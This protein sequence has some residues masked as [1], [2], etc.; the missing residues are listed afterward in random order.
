MHES[1]EETVTARRPHVVPDVV[2]GLRHWTSLLHI[3]NFPVHERDLEILIDIN[4]FGSQI[5]DFVRLTQ[6]R[7]HLI[8]GLSFLDRLRFSLLLLLLWLLILPP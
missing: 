2:T 4:L 3:G 6:S 5:H 8:G 7:F 1:G